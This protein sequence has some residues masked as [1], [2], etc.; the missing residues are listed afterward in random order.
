M[1]WS[2]PEYANPLRFEE[3]DVTLDVDDRPTQGTLTL[4]YGG[5][6]V[7]VV[8]LTGGGPFDRDETSGPN[9]PMKDL[10]WGLASR[11]VAVLRY[12]KP[13][14]TYPELFA[15]PGFTMTQEYVPH[16]VAAVRTL[17]EY[18]DQVF[19]IGHS[20]GGKVAPKVAAAEPGVAGL[21]IMAG[22]TQPMHHAAVR[23]MKHLATIDPAMVPAELVEK[24]ERQAA[25]V[26]SADLSPETPD[27][28][29]GAPGSY[30]LDL[31]TYEAVATAAK[32]DVPILILQGGRDYQVTVADDLPGWQDGLADHPATTIEILAADN[33]Q[34]IAGTGASTP[35]DYEL[36]GHVDPVALGTILD[37]LPAATS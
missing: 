3:A 29:F 2:P 20:M 32:L 33:H 35:A 17:S 13:S 4:P 9:K 8:L 30:W 7:G 21:V 12:D 27:L 36:E 16:A 22:D 15:Q 14:F 6:T 37:W 19:L 10:A 24:F 1:T 31:R 5:A 23:V 28:P 34:F 25:V 26:D 18:V 11:G